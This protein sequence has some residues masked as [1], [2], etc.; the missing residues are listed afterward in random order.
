MNL[1]RSNHTIYKTPDATQ[2]PVDGPHP[3]LATIAVYLHKTQS[4]Y[5]MIEIALNGFKIIHLGAR[6]TIV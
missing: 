6:D 4:M 1:S 2:V 3:T 5:K